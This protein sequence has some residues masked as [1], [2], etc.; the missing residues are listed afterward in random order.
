M[1][2]NR[3]PT[4][5]FLAMKADIE[6]DLNV[7]FDIKN[8]MVQVQFKP[9]GVVSD[10]A[11]QNECV[12]SMI[13]AGNN[14]GGGLVLSATGSGKTYLSGQFFS[15]LKGNGCFIVDEL[16]LLKQAQKELS[17][18][19]NEEVGEVG[20]SKFLP[21]RITVAT[22]QTLHLHQDDPKFEDWVRSLQVN[23]IDEIHVCL[24]RRNVAIVEAIAPPVVFGLTATLE[25]Q[26]QHIRVRAYALAGPV[27]YEYPL[28]QGQEEGHLSQGVVVQVLTE[29][30]YD[31]EVYTNKQY[32]QE[33]SDHIVYNASR[34]E[35]ICDL[36]REAVYQGKFPIVLVERIKHL[37]LLSEMLKDIPHRVV[38]GDVK[39]EDRL[40]AKRKFEAGTIKL[41]LAN[42]V[43]QKGVDIK[44]LDV[45]IDAGAMKSKNR[46][47]QIF[48]RGIRLSE[49]KLGLL[50]FD[51]SDVGGRFEKASKSRRSALMKRGIPVKKFS[52]DR[53]AKELF[54]QGDWFLRRIIGEKQPKIKQLSLSFSMKP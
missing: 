23:I 24:N 43:F 31:T 5:L 45:V 37:Q 13:E 41:L 52:S 40:L 54:K 3:V 6:R 30:D 28:T 25:L 48:G 15:R 22:S 29:N 11:Y 27:C 18:V 1:K 20:D 21:K 34:N 12:E 14:C 17:D 38:C 4:G 46:A 35:L 49:G 50:H 9:N 16:T 33:Y 42:K 10:R 53:G 36:V 8:H 44:K 7:K 47:V 32:A 19:L 51:I 2:R 26:K 39:A